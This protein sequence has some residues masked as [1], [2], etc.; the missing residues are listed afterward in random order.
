MTSLKKHSF[1]E[2]EHKTKNVA[3][4]GAGLMGAGIAQVSAEKG[5][6]VLLKDK[7][8]EG[9]AKGEAYINGNWDKKLKRKK[10]TMHK[11]NQNTANVVGLSDN[12][13]SWKEHFGKA[14]M[15]I[16]AVFEDI[17]LKHKVIKE[18]EEVIPEVRGRS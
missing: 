18:I 14:D 16:E 6:R 12:T 4:L 15:V 5:Y 13:E 7:F 17:D 11:H 3:V 8:D 10:M 2:P 9:L 1:G